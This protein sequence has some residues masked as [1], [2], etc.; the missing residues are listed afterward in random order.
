M[1]RLVSI[2]ISLLI[3]GVIYWKIDLGRLGA[4]LAG[5]SVPWMI[6]SLAMLVPLIL[7]TAWRLLQV[8]PPGCHL[9]YGEA[10][11]LILIASVGN[12]LLPSKMGDIAKAW[13][14]K[15]RG[16]MSGSLALA[17]VVYEKSCD[18]LSLLVWCAFGLFFYSGKDALFWT[19]LISVCAGLAAGF[20]LLRSRR[21]A[22]AMFELGARLGPGKL[23]DKLAQL[24]EGWFDMHA[25]FW[26]NG[27]RLAR[28]AF[29]SLFIWLLHLVQV[30]L[31]ILA[32][33]ASAPFVD[34]CA[35]SALAILAGLLPLTFAGVGTRDAALIFFYQPYLSIPTAAALGILCTLRYV[36]PALAGLPFAGNYLTNFRKT[37]QPGT[38]EK[39]NV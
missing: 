9:S 30:W 36:M 15:E 8:L 26:G 13:F 34:S 25:S 4:V 2:L 18:M 31:F 35:L 5:C 11:R 20:A 23:R 32:L 19:L 22:E 10:N 14:I 1:K 29:T 6:V 38:S 39:L 33:R 21:L 28:I 24:R 16:H 12:L 37:I 27:P 3:L 17:L 7:G